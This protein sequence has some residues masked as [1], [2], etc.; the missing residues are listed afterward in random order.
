[1][2]EKKLFT[3]EFKGNTFGEIAEEF[4]SY[5]FQKVIKDANNSKEG[6]DGLYLLLKRDKK[7]ENELNDCIRHIN[8][9]LYNKYS[10]DMDSTD[11]LGHTIMLMY[12]VLFLTYVGRV[13]LN[14][15]NIEIPKVNMPTNEEVDYKYL[16]KELENESEDVK[17]YRLEQFKRLLNNHMHK[18]LGIFYNSCTQRD[19]KTYFANRAVQEAVRVE[20]RWM[21]LKE[22]KEI[23]INGSRD[24][25]VSKEM[26]N[27]IFAEHTPE[28]YL[29]SKKINVTEYIETI[30]ES[31][32]SNGEDEEFNGVDY[33]YNSSQELSEK[34]FDS[35]QG[36]NNFTSGLFSYL[37]QNYYT[38]LTQKQKDFITYLVSLDLSDEE[39]KLFF[40]TSKARDKYNW[41]YSGKMAIHYKHSITDFIFNLA[42]EDEKLSV[43]PSKLGWSSKSSYVDTIKKLLNEENKENQIDIL[44]SI[45]K[46][47]NKT[48]EIVIDAL[49]D[50]DKYRPCCE[51]IIGKISR[52]KFK[53]IYLQKVLDCLEKLISNK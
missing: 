4:F 17:A 33:F 16:I 43:A 23:L 20:R 15:I 26:L 2:K 1:M 6:V 11:I 38:R 9:N 45:L 7:S 49:I 3:E 14:G 5:S 27:V 19:Y 53:V 25:S 44:L 37:F 30:N 10:K 13:K 36:N 48:A 31:L 12:E 24:I 18:Y 41:K 32:D 34:C 42:K 47:D 28:E 39:L 29:E 8:A 46:K 21:S 51:L 52:Y 50:C 35:V 22:I 40:S